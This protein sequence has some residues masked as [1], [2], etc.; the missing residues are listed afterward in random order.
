MLIRRKGRHELA[1][2]ALMAGVAPLAMP[3]AW[4]QST[5]GT[6]EA[7]AD[8][9]A[10][11]TA[12]SGGIEDIVVTARRRAESLQK[13]PVAV[14]AV[15]SAELEARSTGSISEVAAFT[16]N[17][18]FSESS[19]GGVISNV[20]LRGQSNVNNT[21]ANDPAVG[22]YFDEVYVAR[23]AGALFTAVQDMESVEVLRG[24]QGTLFGRN[25]TGGAILLT[26]KRPDLNEIEG[27]FQA[28]YGNLDRVELGAVLSA[29]LM[30]GKL[31]IRGSILSTKR[32]GIGRSLTTGVDSYGDRD[33]I[34]GRVA[35]RWQPVDDLTLDLTYDI[36]RVHET[37]SSSRNLLQ[38][39]PAGI[40]FDDTLSGVAD[41]RTR[42]KVQGYAARAVYTVAPE[43]ELKTIVSYRKVKFN[44]DRDV[45]G[46]PINSVDSRLIGHQDQTTVE[47]Q[48][49]G[50]FQVGASALQSLNYVAGFY[51]FTEKGLDLGI[52]PL[53]AATPRNSSTD[54]KNDSIAGYGQVEF[55]FTEAISAFAGVRRTRDKRALSVTTITN[56]V[57]NL[58]GNPPGCAFS[59]SAKY[60]FWSWNL[61]GRIAL[62]PDI[63]V[64]AR[65]SKGQRSGGL[66]DTPTDIAS[67]RPEQLQDYEIGLKA[68]LFDRHLRTN[69]ALFTGNYDDIQRTVLLVDA[70]NVPY[71][72][73]FNA[74]KARVR[75]IELEATV[76]P[77]DMLRFSGS[78][79]YTDAKYK[80][81]VD[82]RPGP[83]NGKDASG[84]RFSQVPKWTYSLSA[85]LNVP[86]EI[87]QFQ[88]RVDYNHQSEVFFEV[89][90]TAVLRQ[91]GYSLINARV[92][93]TPEVA[94]RFEPE[95]ALFAKNIGNTRYNVDGVSFGV[96]NATVF[97]DTNPRTYGA[98]VKVRF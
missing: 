36:S 98:E 96:G 46:L 42:A 53:S 8:D 7:A 51:Y 60:A 65:A 29:P 80:R 77:I 70:N 27:S 63:N 82:T 38:P 3:V 15:T 55:Q 66:D 17:L 4:A 86:T 62:S 95:L 31:G 37:G 9:G 12:P 2:Y 20:T 33:R 26:P 41:P 1:L 94:G 79:G 74:A 81:F 25:S 84:N 10:A 57:C 68:D 93:Y 24:N 90:N 28:S 85:D 72:S 32:D 54:G 30:E 91:K 19:R 76:Q 71:S 11:R 18:R 39:V 75:G 6:G 88:G 50:Q 92:S 52:T 58:A 67:F 16:P 83:N 78:L 44:N 48:A 40:D 21:I 22:I 45:D 59:G 89:F 14:T 13:V 23:S 47:L 56:G 73:V 87:G 97:R 49:S 5:L 35:L 61:G 64:Y 69:L 34:S 43:L